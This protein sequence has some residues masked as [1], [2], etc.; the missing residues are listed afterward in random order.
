MTQ[1]HCF[2]NHCQTTQIIWRGLSGGK[3]I[4]NTSLKQLKVVAYNEGGDSS[5][6]HLIMLH[7]KLGL[8]PLVVEHEFERN[9]A[10][11]W[12]CLLHGCRKV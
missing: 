3:D 12:T 6:T 2:S 11:E 5:Y 1:V 10:R 9:K 8:G 7:L 4:S